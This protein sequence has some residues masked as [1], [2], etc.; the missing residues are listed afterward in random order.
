MEPLSRAALITFSAPDGL[1]SAAWMS[2]AIL[3]AVPHLQV[4]PQ[5]H[6]GAVVGVAW[7]SQLGSF[8]RYPNIGLKLSLRLL[9]T[10]QAAGSNGTAAPPR[11]ELTRPQG[12]LLCFRGWGGGEGVPPQ[13]DWLRCLPVIWAGP[14]S[15]FLGSHHLRG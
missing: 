13:F 3:A 9:P 12:P 4:C 10:M 7:S 6:C 8:A 15:S 14:Q 2:A 1:R 5:G 11:I